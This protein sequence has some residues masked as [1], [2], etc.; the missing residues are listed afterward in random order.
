M[1]NNKVQD[2]IDN[3]VGRSSFLCLH[4]KCT[5]VSGK[6][7]NNLLLRTSYLYSYKN[8]FCEQKI[9]VSI[10]YFRF[11]DFTSTYIIHTKM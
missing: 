10:V 5:A 2:V 11:L 6:I 7:V 3:F 4:K 1:V 9:G 8:L